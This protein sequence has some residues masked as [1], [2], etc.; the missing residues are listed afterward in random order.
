MEVFERNPSIRG[1]RICIPRRCRE[2]HS[3]LL[4]VE[5]RTEATVCQQEHSQKR[6]DEVAQ[7]FPALRS[8]Q[9]RARHIDDMRAIL[10]W[11]G[12]MPTLAL[13]FV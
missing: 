7:N 2:R 11:G 13:S 9:S 12:E 1:S 3:I 4:K 10:S 5:E 6:R 8:Y